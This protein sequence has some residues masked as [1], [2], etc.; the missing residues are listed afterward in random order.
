MWSR[1]DSK[2]SQVVRDSLPSFFATDVF[3]G[4][5]S[6]NYAP[7]PF[8]LYTPRDK[9]TVDSLMISFLWQVTSDPDL[10]P[11]TYIFH[12]SGA[13][14]DT[15][16]A[17]LTDNRF[18]FDGR[19]VLQDNTDYTWYIEATDGTD[20]TASTVQRTLRTPTSTG[21]SSILQVPSR[22]SLSQNYPNPFNAVTEI[23]FEVTNSDQIELSVFN[24]LGEKV[25]T[26]EQGHFGPGRYKT[27]FDA[28]NL[29][30]GIYYFQLKTS[31]QCIR[32][33]SVYIR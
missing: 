12:L 28:S 30:S 33:K 29:C 18:L 9:N 13:N 5:T 27:R 24:S 1:P 23:L 3:E 14:L 15:T 20:T 4:G 25:R 2:F 16:I 10:D 7:I 11:V 32:R 8:T 21:V 22:F 19:Q 26:L 31:L 6:D 17:N